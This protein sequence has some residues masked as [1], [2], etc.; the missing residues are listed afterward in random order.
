[1]KRFVIILM[2]ATSSILGGCT[3][4]P[5]LLNFPVDA[6]GRSLNSRSAE[7][8]PQ[9]TSTYIVFVSDRNG[10]QDVY[11][12][13]AQ[14][15]QL[16]ALPGLN[17]LDEIASHPSISEDGRY[18]VFGSSRQGKSNIYLYD[19]QTEQKRNLTENLAAEV[20]NPTINAD[21]TEIAFEVAKDGQWDIMIY[22][23][24]GNPIR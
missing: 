7:L 24:S 8:D 4:Y 2:V 3:G 19:R 5:R 9:I 13:D 22:D 14:K 17:S 20:R 12:F 21:G 23:I 10:S 11:L 6:G 18:L 15:R 1:M 16:I